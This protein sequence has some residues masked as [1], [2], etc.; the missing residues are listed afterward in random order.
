M[1]NTKPVRDSRNILWTSSVNGFNVR[2]PLTEH[3]I[4]Y[5]DSLHLHVQRPRYI[6][7]QTALSYNFNNKHRE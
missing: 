7:Y 3:T 4:F 1:N 5:V 2:P 6:T